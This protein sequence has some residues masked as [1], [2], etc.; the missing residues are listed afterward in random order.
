MNPLHGYDVEDM[1]PG[2][3]ASFAKSVTD[4]D[5]AAYAAVAGDFNPLHLSD[6]YAKTTL[7]RGRIAHGMLSAGFI[8]AALGN[9]LPGPGC[10]YL[11]Q[12]LK[13]KGPVRPGDTV[14][15][16]VTVKSVVPEKKRVVL[17]SVC[18]VN[19]KV[20]LEGEATML[21]TSAGDRPAAVTQPAL[22]YTI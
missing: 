17:E 3:T 13:F 16:T 5:I 4:A 9:Q 6:D 1:A 7:F 20:V 10:V 2:M 8:S 11:G 21:C 18:A 12:T 22:A 14:T 19:G 15:T